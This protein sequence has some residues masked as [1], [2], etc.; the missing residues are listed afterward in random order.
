MKTLRELNNI[1]FG[2]NPFIGESGVYI[3][4]G[5]VRAGVS[6]KLLD[7]ETGEVAGVTFFHTVEDKDDEDFVKI[8]DAGI[9]ASFDLSKAAL[10]VFQTVLA[11]YSK[12]KMNGRFV[13]VVNIHYSNKKL[14]GVVID[15]SERTF[16]NGLKELMIKRFLAKRFGS[17]YWVNHALF[18]RGN[19]VA[20]IKEYRRRST[21]A[22]S[23]AK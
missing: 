2:D 16:Q 13:E 1:C 20:L 23:S 5:T 3:K 17:L 21:G 9:A 12:M 14:N 19:R 18:F 15:M 11:E 8:F 4:K 7:V 6:K 10:R 22:Q